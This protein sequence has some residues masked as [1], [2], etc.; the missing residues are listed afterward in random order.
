MIEDNIS[1]DVCLVIPRSVVVLLLCFPDRLPCLSSFG[2]P[3][4]CLPGCLILHFSLCILMILLLLLLFFHHSFVHQPFIRIRLH[5]ANTNSSLV[6]HLIVI[7]PLSG[8]IHPRL[9]PSNA[10]LS[11]RHR[12]PPISF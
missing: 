4:S 2:N 9:L 1:N 7:Q 12:L 8:N 5:S 6:Y 3:F 11:M 10:T